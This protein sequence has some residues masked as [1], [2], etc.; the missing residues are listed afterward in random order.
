MRPLIRF[1]Y[2]KARC[3]LC[4]ADHGS[5]KLYRSIRALRKHLNRDHSYGGVFSYEIPSIPTRNGTYPFTV[6]GSCS[7]GCGEP[8]RFPTPTAIT[9]FMPDHGP[10]YYLAG[11]K[12]RIYP[13]SGMYKKGN[14]PWCNGLKGKGICKPNSGSFKKGCIPSNDRG[15]LRTAPNGQVLEW[16][17][18]HH[19][20]GTRKYKPRTRRIMEEMLG[21]ALQVDEVVIH[22]DGNASND[23]PSNLK[24]I[25]RSENATRNRWKGYRTGQNMAD[26]KVRPSRSREVGPGFCSKCRSLMQPGAPCPRCNING[27]RT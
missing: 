13:N 5:R 23:D 14:I 12:S 26:F 19:P 15:G 7:C 21:R 4:L 11:H 6:H 1:K 3:P 10:P 2:G 22:L 9:P 8:V 24:V 20:S 17:G 25:S 27:G 18:E 16:T